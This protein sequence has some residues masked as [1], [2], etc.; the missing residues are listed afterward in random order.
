MALGNPDRSK[1]T[2]NYPATIRQGSGKAQAR[3]QAL[4]TTSLGEYS[5]VGSTT[6]RALRPNAARSNGTGQEA[7]SATS[8]HRPPVGPLRHRRAAGELKKIK[9]AWA[10]RR[11]LQ[12]LDHGW[13]CGPALPDGQGRVGALALAAAHRAV[14]TAARGIVTPRS[15]IYLPIGHPEGSYESGPLKGFRLW[16]GIRD[17]A[18]LAAASGSAGRLGESGW[19][20]R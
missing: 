9:D 20:G 8:G 13:N 5:V 7:K 3:Q 4:K 15:W 12:Q 16:L 10:R 18:Q 2:G 1:F 17:L 11:R 14:A 6:A 19:R